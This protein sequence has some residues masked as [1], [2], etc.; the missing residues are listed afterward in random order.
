MKAEDIHPVKIAFE[1]PVSREQTV[2]RLVYGYILDGERLFL[3]DTGIAGA[4]KLFARA[5]EAIGKSLADIDV[6]ILTH[7]HPDHIGAAGR[8][9][10]RSGAEVWAHPDE[11]PWMED[12][13]RQASERPVPGFTAMVSGP[14]RIG[15]T[16]EEGDAFSVAEGWTFTVLHTPG[17]SRGSISLLAEEQGVLFCGDAVPQPGGLPIYEDVLALAFS[18]VR[19]AKIGNLRALH[20]SWADPLFGPGAGEAIIAGMRYLDSVH[21]VVL[22]VASEINR[23][24]P[25]ELCR[26]CVRRL[27][28][29]PF[30]VNPLVARSL[31][32]HTEEAA[33]ASLGSILAPFVDGDRSPVCPTGPCTR[34]GK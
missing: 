10:A 9:Q 19:L 14:V 12:V 18:L 31:F 5:L 30:A 13:G 8:L 2:E 22:Q 7:S 15:R 21:K 16:L 32:A 6:L 27:E 29:P 1:I 33:R 11:R 3:I 25:L 4:E 28:L 24:D 34:G 20:S 17:H 23:P 26:R